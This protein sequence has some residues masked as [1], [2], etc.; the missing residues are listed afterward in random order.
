MPKPWGRDAIEND[1]AFK[2]SPLSAAIM[3]HVLI[4]RAYLEVHGTGSKV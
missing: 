3:K 2:K 4:R 1:I